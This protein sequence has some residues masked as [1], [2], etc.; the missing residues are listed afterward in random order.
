MSNA[1]RYPWH[2][3]W[4]NMNES[5]W[6]FYLK[7]DNFKYGF[8]KNVIYVGNCQNSTCLKMFKGAVVNWTSNSIGTWCAEL[9]RSI[10]ELDCEEGSWNPSSSAP[11]PAAATAAATRLFLG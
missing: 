2:I 4:S 7:I 10:L 1:Q 5:S 8:L 11:S 3:F 9:G 6:F